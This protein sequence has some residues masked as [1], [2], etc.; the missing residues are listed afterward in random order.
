MFDFAV[1]TRQMAEFLMPPFQI[2]A[3]ESKRP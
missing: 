1:M 3:L 2:N